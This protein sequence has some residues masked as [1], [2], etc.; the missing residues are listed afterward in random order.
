[1]YN[2][3]KSRAIWTFTLFHSFY[4]NRRSRFAK[5]FP[6]RL[7]LLQRSCSFRGARAEAIFGGARALPNRPLELSVETKVAAKM[8]L[9]PLYKSDCAEAEGILRIDIVYFF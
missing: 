2:Q 4:T 7:Q 6:E 3:V 9:L 1:M 5:R 8:T